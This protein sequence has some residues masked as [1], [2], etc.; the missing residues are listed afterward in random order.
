MAIHQDS[1]S[2]RV[3]LKVERPKPKPEPIYHLLVENT[4]AAEE[5]REPTPKLFFHDFEYKD[6]D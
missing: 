2:N 1:S 6:T 5:K 4:V 3:I